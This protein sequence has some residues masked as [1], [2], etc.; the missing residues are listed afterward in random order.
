MREVVEQVFRFKELEPEAKR[1]AMNW[2]IETDHFYYDEIE[3]SLNAFCNIFPVKWSEI[4]ASIGRIETQINVDEDVLNLR[5]WRLATYIYNN[6][7][8][9]LFTG[10][11]YSKFR[12]VEK[13]KEHPAGLMLFTR[14]SKIFWESS[15][16]MT[17]VCYDDD[18]LKP[19]IEFLDNPNESSDLEDLISDGVSNLASS[20]NSEYEHRKT[21]DYIAESCEANDYEFYADGSNY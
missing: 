14:H 16:P 18:L 6:Y 9:Y 2:F 13:S 15:C 21:E 17:G 11:Y 7:R 19:F 20:I 1:K 5:G 3:A 4:D 8:E 10:K 12:H